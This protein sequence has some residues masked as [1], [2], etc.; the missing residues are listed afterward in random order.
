MAATSASL[1][2]QA[3][4]SRARNG[5]TMGALR[6]WNL[7]PV[8]INS[9]FLGCEQSRQARSY[10]LQ[11]KEEDNTEHVLALTM[12]FLTEDAKEECNVVEVMSQNHDNEKVAVPLANLKLSCQPTL[13]LGDFP[14]Q[15]PVTF[16]LKSGSVPVHVTARH[17]IVSM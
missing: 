8:H 17:Q 10:T 1:A 3:Q 13:S 15:P 14:L 7:G 4:G 2:F 11:V 9:F 5:G 16:H 6:L 12:L